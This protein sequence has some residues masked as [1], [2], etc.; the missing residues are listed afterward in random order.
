MGVPVNVWVRVAPAAALAMTALAF[1][2]FA[3]DTD[4]PNHNETKEQRD[5]RMAWWREAKFGMFI[6]RGVY[7]VP[8][9]AYG[10]KDDYGE[11]IMHD[12]RI[13]MAEYAKFT[14]RFNPVKFN[15]EEWV[16]A[17]KDAGQKYIVI[18]AKHHDG[19]A[20][21]PSKASDYNIR[22]AT[23]FKR[24]PLKE[25]AAACEKEGIKLGF[26]YSQAQDWGHPGGA[27]IGGHWDPAQEGDFDAYLD[28]VAL[29]QVKELLSNYGPSAP[30]VLWFDTPVNMTPER[31]ARFFPLLKTRPGLIINNRLGG[32]FIG[33]TETPEQLIPASGFPGRDWET[34]MTMNRHWGYCRKDTDW[35]SAEDL[36]RKLV[37]IA[38]KG[39]NYLLNVGPTSE[40]LIPAASVERL[41]QVGA[42]MKIN[43]ESIYGTTGGPFP[44]LSWG[45]ATRKGQRLFLHV[46]TWPSNGVLRVPLAN[47][48]SA[49]A[50]LAQPGKKLEVRNEGNLAL[51]SLPGIAPDAV[52]SVVTLDFEGDPSFRRIPR[53]RKL[54]VHR[55]RRR[56]P[57]CGAPGRRGQARN[58]SNN[59]GNRPMKILWVALPLALWSVSFAD[60][61]QPAMTFDDL[62]ANYSQT[63]YRELIGKV[64]RMSREELEA[65][66]TDIAD[67]ILV[68]QKDV[69]H[70]EAVRQIGR[71]PPFDL[72]D[73]ANWEPALRPDQDVVKPLQ[74]KMSAAPRAA[75]VRGFWNPVYT[76]RLVH[77]SACQLNNLGMGPVVLVAA[78]GAPVRAISRDADKPV[79][80]MLL[81]DEVFVAHF[82][83][84]SQ[85]YY[86]V[87]QVEWF[88]PRTAK[89]SEAAPE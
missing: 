70:T 68:P 38:S 50:L 28:Q 17:A 8:A 89:P 29:P 21:F 62:W 37:E 2:A 5:A 74:D 19:F 24:D 39:G 27:A 85:G 4:A 87:R 58:G 1:P 67:R 56:I 71:L 63:A 10:D 83:Y 32:G 84:A 7:S 65:A 88:K 26:Y 76:I 69:L 20:L 31:A 33:D 53:L 41:K 15:A 55:E 49:A 59:G 44:Y 16:K 78:V 79:L 61:A 43:G 77:T 82:E 11:W 48:I 57:A 9:G 86:E 22:D 60:D 42:W 72:G 45:R 30:A 36:I 52:D 40:G 25:L 75:K 23:P 54:E 35:K 12:A 18:T 64:D 6:H 46:Q 66:T 81:G 51:V 34:C 14:K 73:M 3:A 13:P 80:A 47:K